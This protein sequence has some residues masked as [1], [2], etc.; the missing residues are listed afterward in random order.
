LGADWIVAIVAVGLGCEVVGVLFGVAEVKASRRAAMA[1]SQSVRTV[2]VAG[3]ARLNAVVT[4]TGT[5]IV[6]PAHESSEQDKAEQRLKAHEAEIGALRNE[7]A[8]SERR[9]MERWQSDLKAVAD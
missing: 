7:L 4:A 1:L 5:V 2:Y 6:T 3:I 8:A 9:V